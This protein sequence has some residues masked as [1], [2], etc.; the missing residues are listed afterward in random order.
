MVRGAWQT[1]AHGVAKTCKDTGSDMTELLTL[2]FIPRNHFF[3]FFSLLSVFSERD[4]M[5][6]FPLVFTGFFISKIVI[7]VSWVKRWTSV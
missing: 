1:R 6:L 5:K 4:H 3:F 2:H 7:N